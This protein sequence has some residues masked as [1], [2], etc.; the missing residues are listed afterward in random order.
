[1]KNISIIIVIIFGISFFSFSQ[2]MDKDIY[3]KHSLRQDGEA[4]QFTVIDP[5]KKGVFH[6]DKSK[7]YYWFKAQKVISTQGGSSGLVLNGEF[8]AFY[9]NKQLS[10]KGNF[11]K[12]LKN[13]EW[14]YWRTDGTLMRVEHWKKGRLFG[15]EMFYDEKGKL[16]STTN[17]T[18]WS[19]SRKTADSLIVSNHS[20]TKKTISTFD[21]NG[22]IISKKTFKKGKE[23]DSKNK[24]KLGSIFKKKDT[25]I[26]SEKRTKKTESGTKK[27]EKSSE[28]T[29]EKKGWFKFLKKKEK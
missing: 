15:N 4:Y 29:K 26:N 11:C 12:G 3:L 20:G 7:Y 2:E 27:D 10:K 17:Y 1:M 24:K 9:D 18:H 22:N 21:E 14:F 5:D 13:G 16:Q 25:S 19:F 6:H 23:I 28:T 8:E